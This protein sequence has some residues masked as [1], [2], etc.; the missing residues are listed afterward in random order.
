MTRSVLAKG[1]TSSY[2]KLQV[3]IPDW[4]KGF[5]FEEEVNL[6]EKKDDLQARLREVEERTDKLDQFKSI[7]AAFLPRAG[8]L[9][10]EQSISYEFVYCLIFG[11]IQ[12]T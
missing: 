1:L 12:L 4:V 8:N 3:S 9:N 6:T 2:N 7:L 5:A 11:R 10:A